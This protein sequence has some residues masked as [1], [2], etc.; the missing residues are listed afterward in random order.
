MNLSGASSLAHWMLYT[1]GPWVAGFV[2][3]MGG[4]LIALKSRNRNNLR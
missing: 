1:A 2:V 3:V 4:I